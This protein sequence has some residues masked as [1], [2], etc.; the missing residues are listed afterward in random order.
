MIKPHGLQ[1]GNTD[2]CNPVGSIDRMSEHLTRLAR[3]RAVQKARGW[4]D[5][6]LARQIGRTQQQ[7]YSWSHGKH[8]GERLARHIEEALGLARY[9]LDERDDLVD[10]LNMV[11]E[12][13][14]RPGAFPTHPHRATKQARPIPVV[15]WPDIPAMLETDNADTVPT[16]PRISTYAPCSVRAKFLQMPDDSMLP[17]IA[18]G[19]HLLL[20]PTEV[21]RGGDT[22]LVRIRSGEHFVRQF[23]P[24]TAYVFEATAVNGLHL[25]LSSVADGATVVAVLVEHR[26]YRQRP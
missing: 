7:V 15:P 8:I 12:R 14:P 24:K 23:Q 3:I 16:V 4:D 21:P 6:E 25:P 2:G 9:D 10:P 17:L 22:V 26:R 18:E 19:D 1:P 20:D 5:A 13:L 11:G